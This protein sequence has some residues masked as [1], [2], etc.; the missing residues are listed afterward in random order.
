MKTLLRYINES[1]INGMSITN[2][3]L[4]E[5]VHSE[6]ENIIEENGLDVRILDLY[7]IMMAQLEKTH[8][9]IYCMMMNMKT[10]SHMM[11]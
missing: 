3:E 11:A 8:F 9:S 7:Y 2:D 10:F 4:I 5:Y 1:K 6:V